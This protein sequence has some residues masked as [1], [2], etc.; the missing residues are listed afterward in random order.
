MLP[1]RVEREHDLLA[2]LGNEY[3]SIWLS[4][5]R[6]GNDP[7]LRVMS[8]RDRNERLFDATALSLL[9]HADDVVMGVIADIARDK[10]A[11]QELAA[12]AESRRARRGAGGGDD[13]DT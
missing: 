3:A 4:V 5:D 11:R 13:R 12:W 1:E 8:M 7:R 9:C 10:A 2:T 6:D